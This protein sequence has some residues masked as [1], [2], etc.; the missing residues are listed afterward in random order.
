MQSYQLVNLSGSE[1]KDRKRQ[2]NEPCRGVQRHVIEDAVDLR[3]IDNC[4]RQS[5]GD[6]D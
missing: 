3:D 2:D 4:K 5:Q 6:Q 1:R